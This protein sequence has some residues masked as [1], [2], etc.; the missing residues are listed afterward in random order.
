M[1]DDSSGRRCGAPRKVLRDLLVEFVNTLPDR[2][3]DITLL[4]YGIEAPKCTEEQLA[5]KFGE[6]P[7]GISKSLGDI[8]RWLTRVCLIRVAEN[9]NESVRD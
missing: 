5:V 6:S 4:H 2:E 1:V 8:H 3:R 9:Y 7:E